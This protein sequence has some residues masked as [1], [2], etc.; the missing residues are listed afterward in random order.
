MKH[1]KEIV[2]AAMEGVK[3]YLKEKGVRDEYA[4]SP[5]ALDEPPGFIVKEKATG[6]FIHFMP[7]EL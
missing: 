4:V 6:R 2:E 5:V 1:H 3:H 7:V